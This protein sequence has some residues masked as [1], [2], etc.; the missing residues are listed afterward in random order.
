MDFELMKKLSEASG[1]PGSEHEVADIMLKG[2]RAAGFTVRQ[3]KMG[4]VI[5][6]KK[7]KGPKI[8]LGAHMD[9]IGLVV[10]GI[11]DKGFLRFM[12]IGGIDD[13]VLPNQRVVV[14]TEKGK[15]HGVIGAKPPHSQE[16]D[17]GK[18]AIK[19]KSMFI[20]IGASSKKE[21]E[22]MGL[23]IGDPISFSSP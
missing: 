18:R 9:E 7:G 5:A 19:S 21:A 6:E 10:K 17:E 11:D 20:D 23:R 22:K 16:D 4:D 14:L 15:V 2:F 3:S 12:K 13:R 1:V 8:M